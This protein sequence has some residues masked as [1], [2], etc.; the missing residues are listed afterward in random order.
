MGQHDENAIFQGIRNGDPQILKSFYNRNFN[1]ILSYVTRNSGNENDA[2]DIFQDALISLYQFLKKEETLHL[3]CSIHT[4]FYSICRNLWI[5]K[6]RRAGKVSCCGKIN[7]IALELE[8]S[9]LEDVEVKEQEQ[10]YRK[11]LLSLNCKCKNILFLFFE[12]KSMKEISKLTNYSEGYVRK[13]KFECKEY[14]IQLIEN[15]PMYKELML[16][17]RRNMR[18]NVS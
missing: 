14:L 5:S 6:L 9:I 17:S 16:P 11:H 13:R 3:R 12:G 1:I 10:L 15:D 18:K 8:P 7:E 2:E 4:Y